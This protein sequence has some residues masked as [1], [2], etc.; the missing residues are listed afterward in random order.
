MKLHK[1]LMGSVVAW[2]RSQLWLT[3]M[4]CVLGPG[5][6]PMARA[7]VVMWNANSATST[8]G[9][10]SEF[11]KL[12]N[13]YDQ[14]G[15][16]TPYFRGQ[17]QSSY[18]V[19]K[20]HYATL[21]GTEWVSSFS[22]ASGYIEFDLGAALEVYNVVV[23]NEETIGTSLIRIQISETT[24]FSLAPTLGPFILDQNAGVLPYPSQLITLPSPTFGR[25]VRLDPRA[26]LNQ[27]L[28]AL[29]E[30]AFGVSLDTAIRAGV[31]ES[32]TVTAGV[33][34]ALLLGIAAHKARRRRH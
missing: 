20:T 28:I 2:V 32:S 27:D 11:T 26:N 7:Q 17:L 1:S 3:G 8:L 25:Y 31:P 29:G 14:T 5:L 13:V 34:L 21:S 22:Q 12:S 15:L 19:S 23:W 6:V 33:S 4:A 10:F 16:L 9:E 18:L 30:V 24:D